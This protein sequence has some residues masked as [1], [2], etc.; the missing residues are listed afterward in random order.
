ML[1]FNNIK[2]IVFDMAGTTVNEGGIVYKT[3]L[4]TM[5]DYGLNVSSMEH[6]WYGSNK[7]E[8]LNHYLNKENI[9]CEKT[10]NKV[11]QL[12]FN[13]LHQEYFHSNQIKLID[14]N[15]P[16]LFSN[17]QKN[18]IKIA[19]NTGYNQEIQ[20]KIIHKL[21]MNEFID[22]YI[23][24]EEVLQGRPSPDM[25]HALMKQSQIIDPKQVMKV[26]D[27]P[28]DILEG[29]NAECKL[30]VGVLSGAGTKDTLSKA[31]K[32]MDSVM[33]IHHW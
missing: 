13:N 22:H 24:S 7:K 9:V 15:L 3:L 17:F 14:E 18:G 5:K 2:L 32:I 27:S 8:V 10:Q 6:W 16:E 11:H 29:L 28:N 26:G 12:F 25:I 19:L 21:H 30:T 23:S 20:S 33:N 4:S 1:L 31:D